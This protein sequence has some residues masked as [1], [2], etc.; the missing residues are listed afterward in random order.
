MPLIL[1]I[2]LVFFN[3]G[4]VTT[5]SHHQIAVRNTS[6]SMITNSSSVYSNDFLK[7][8]QFA[9]KYLWPILPIFFL[10]IGT[11]LNIM[12]ILV[13]IRREMIKFSSFC[14]FAVLN[15]VNLA[16]LYVTIIRIIMEHNFHSDIRKLNL[17]SCKSH[18]FLTY[19]LSHLSSLLLCA[20]SVDRAISVMFLRQ[21]KDLCTPRVAWKVTV[22]LVVFSFLLSSHFLILDSGHEETIS[23][24][25]NSNNKTITKIVIHCDARINSTYHAFV[26]HYWKLID[27]TMYAFLPFLIMLMCS[28]IIL[29]RVAQQSKKF[30][31][32]PKNT[33]LQTKKDNSINKENNLSKKN[34]SQRNFSARTRN[35]ALML[36][37]VNVLFLIFLAPV[38]IAMF[39][40]ERLG[41]DLLTLALVEFL[42][43][44][45]FS[46]NFFIYFLTSSKFR[47]EFI[48]M[49]D[50]MFKKLKL[51]KN[52]I[53]IVERTVATRQNNKQDAI[54]ITEL[55]PLT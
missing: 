4:F 50:E 10:I 55:S 2:L 28:F 33:E 21:A 24:H 17:F 18:V 42:S 22:S 47:E 34:Q 46:L 37:P 29:V 7:S 36:I 20:I 44:F 12:A 52:E 51:K 11:F 38:V 30:Q 26:E 13:F 6:H 45:N 31:K 40:Y 48:K 35:L 25:G 8:N 41:E 54:N 43:Y 23:E 53:K 39:T 5:E 3:H 15:F 1:V 16:F 32:K 49:M 19:F 14:Y 9:N 27:M